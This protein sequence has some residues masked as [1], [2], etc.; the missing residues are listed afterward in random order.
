[1]RVT[2]QC[3]VCGRPFETEDCPSRARYGTCCSRECQY[4]GLRKSRAESFW[5][6][7]NKTGL[8][9]C[10]LWMSSTVPFGHGTFT[11]REQTPRTQR[12]HR[13]SGE[14]AN[15]PIPAGLL[16]CHHCDVPACV[17]PDHL[18]LGTMKAMDAARK[19][20]LAQQTDKAKYILAARKRS[21]L[22]PETVAVI[23][24]ELGWR[25]GA[26]IGR[27]YGVSKAVISALRTGKTWVDADIS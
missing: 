20:R 5:G 3:K 12:A 2:R 27:K 15:G 11:H 9:G 26:R 1:M 19:G 25:N 17:N 14:F 7:V 8:G 22:T 21:K 6:L 18:F 4:A 13:V 10:W 24:A 16:V 23:R